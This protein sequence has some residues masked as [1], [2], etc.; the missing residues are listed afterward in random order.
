MESRL[1]P[2]AKFA[3]TSYQDRYRIGV[4]TGNDEVFVRPGPEAGVEPDCLLPLVTGDDVRTGIRWGGSYLVNPFRPDASGAVR[5]LSERP[6]L[7]P[8][9]RPGA[10]SSRDGA[11][12]RFLGFPV[13]T[14]EETDR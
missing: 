4:A 12:S 10:T 2:L 8:R 6:G 14:A 13:R 7:R 11:A 5:D 9:G 3:G 1:P